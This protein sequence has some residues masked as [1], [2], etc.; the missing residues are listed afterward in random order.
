MLL[1]TGVA[2]VPRS[3]ASAAPAVPI[4]L[5]FMSWSLCTGKLVTSS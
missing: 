1:C 2:P 5:P 4:F 3:Q